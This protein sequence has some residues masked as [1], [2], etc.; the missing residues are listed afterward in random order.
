MRHEPTILEDLMKAIPWG[1][2]DRLVAAR[3]ANDKPRSFDSRDH[4]TAM[5]GAALGGLSG[6][7][8]TVA[9]LLPG[10]GPMH[11]M[12]TQPPRRST[13][14]DANRQRDP[15]LF[16]DLLMAMLPCLDRTDRRE[17]RNAARLIDST[18]VNL[19]RRMCK[20][21]GPHRGEPTAKIHVVYDPRAGQ[22]VYFALTPAK[23]SDIAAARR[24]LP[25]E[26]GATDVF[27]LAYYDFA[28]FAKP[29][30]NNRTFVTRLKCNTRMREVR[31][32]AV[33]AGGPIV[34][35]RTGRLAARLAASRRNPFGDVG[36]EV[37]VEI[38]AKRTL[39][40]FTNDLTSSRSDQLR[41]DHCR[42][43]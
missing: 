10:R 1:A 9:G 39:R 20:W 11:L 2:F 33:A 15:G 4:L 36:R 22:S 23:V 12:G 34:S 24:M 40:L 6:L 3:R 32:R 28:W 31:H 14:A 25:I 37:V 35:D 5:I 43:L 38:D 42:P 29:R 41:G 7:R 13:L 30:D 18:Q 16:L 19:G 27:D 21:V 17:M 26:A 8:Q